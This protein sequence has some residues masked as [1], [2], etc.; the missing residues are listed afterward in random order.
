MS[1]LNSV[2]VT[3]RFWRRYRDPRISKED[4]ID[5][6]SREGDKLT[7]DN[8]DTKFVRSFL[9]SRTVLKFYDTIL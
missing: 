7:H 5:T 9:S 4:Q 8:M 6:F 3:C 2:P 1:S